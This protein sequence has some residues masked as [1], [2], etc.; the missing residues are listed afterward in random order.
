MTTKRQK[1]AVNFCEL[2]L[3][4]KFKGDI[5]D[6]NQVSNFL[7]INLDSAKLIADEATS[8]YYS[9]FMY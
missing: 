2:W 3:Q 1:A 6:F 9:E 8:S 5:D 4:V 7:S